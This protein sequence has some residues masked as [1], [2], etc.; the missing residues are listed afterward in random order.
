MLDKK[1][2][3]LMLGVILLVTFL[4][5]S[6]VLKSDF[7]NWDDDVNVT[8]NPNVKELTGESIKNMFSTTVIGGYTPLTTLSYAVETSLFGMKPGVY[9]FNNL[10]LHLL[11]T[12]MVFIF[13]R[14]LGA[15]LFIVFVTT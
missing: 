2:D 12:L 10:M 7:V 9:H 13:L 3:W 8:L 4:S 11:C 14:R 1:R 5:F 6:P 15:S